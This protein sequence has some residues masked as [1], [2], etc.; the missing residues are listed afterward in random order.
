MIVSLANRLAYFP[1][2]PPEKSY[3]G[4]I[5]SGSFLERALLILSPFTSGCESRADNSDRL[6]DFR[7]YH[8]HG[9]I[10]TGSS[11]GHESAFLD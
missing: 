8:D 5:S 4:N 2:R 11:N 6:P 1:R 7:V 10:S 9:S 3:S